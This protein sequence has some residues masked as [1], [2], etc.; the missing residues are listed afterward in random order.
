LAISIGSR[1][2][3]TCVRVQHQNRA[4]EAP[5]SADSLVFLRDVPSAEVHENR[6][7]RVENSSVGTDVA[8]IVE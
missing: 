6:M 1:E 8:D 3:L 4:L 5:K 2:V 7:C